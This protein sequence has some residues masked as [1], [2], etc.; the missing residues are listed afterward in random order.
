MTIRTRLRAWL[1]NSN[2]WQRLW[3]LL[4]ILTLLGLFVGLSFG[5]AEIGPEG[6][7]RY[8]GSLLCAYNDSYFVCNV[9]WVFLWMLAMA[10]LYVLGWVIAWIADGFRR[11][12]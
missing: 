2:G 5:K 3:C 10:G 4:V 11:K 8:L 9:L 1:K 7:S 12:E 6:E